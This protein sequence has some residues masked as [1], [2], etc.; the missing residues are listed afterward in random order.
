MGLTYL[1]IKKTFLNG[2]YMH[3]SWCWAQNGRQVGPSLYSYSGAQ[4]SAGVHPQRKLARIECGPN[5][6]STRGD[7][8]VAFPETTL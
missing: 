6:Q 1:F 8:G 7:A 3:Y 5:P 2:Y 4:M